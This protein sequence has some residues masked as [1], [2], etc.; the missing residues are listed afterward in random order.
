M[1]K[2]IFELAVADANVTAQLDK[3]RAQLKEINKELKSAEPGSE[4]FDK[5]AVEAQQAKSVIADLTQTQKALNREFAATKVPSDSLAGLRLEYSKLVQQISLLSEAERNGKVG[6]ELIRNA[7]GIKDQ[8]NGIQES[9]GNFTGSVGNYKGGILAAFDALQSLGGA[10]G[11]QAGVLQ[12]ARQAF[13]AA[14]DGAQRF[15][16]A[17]TKGVENIRQGR[18]D[19]AQYLESLRQSKTI[20]KEAAAAAG[21]AGE[22]V[23]EAAKEGVAAGAGLAESA[24]G[25]SLFARAGGVLKTVLSGLGIGLLISLL[26]GLIGVFQRFAP[27]IDLVEQ[28]AAGLSA[29]FDVLISRTGRLVDGFVKIFS[30]DFKAG[31]NEVAESVTGIGDAMASAATEAAGLKKELQDLEDAQ[32]DFVLQ[33]AQAEA[34]VK[35]LEVALKDRTRS[36]GNRLKIAAQIAAIESKNLKDKT[37]IIDKE[38]DIEKRRL[39]LTGQVTQEQANQIAAGNFELARQ[40]EDNFKLNADQTD[41]IRDLLVQRTNAEGESAV[42]LERIQNRKNAIL[43]AAA[44]KAAASAEKQNKAIEAQNARV[45]ELEKAVRDLD[46]SLILNDFDKQA[47]D[48]ENKRLDAIEKIAQQSAALKQKIQDAG[49]VLTDRDKEEQKLIEQETRGVEAAYKAQTD[50]LLKA[51]EAARA[52]QEAELKALFNEVQVLAKQNGEELANIESEILNSEFLKKQVELK[53]VLQQRQ[54]DLNQSLI[55]GA[56]TRKQFEQETIAAQSDFNIKS[57]TL[58]KERVDK[59]TQ[60]AEDLRNAKIASA[61]ASLTAELDAIRTAADADVQ[62]LRDRATKEGVDTTEQI[63]QREAQALEKRTAAYNNYAKTVNDANK[64]ATQ[65]QIE[66]LNAVNDAD[67][68]VQED[69]LRRIDEEKKKRGEL[70]DFLLSTANTIA[71]AIFDI[72]KN[73]QQ[74]QTETALQSLEEEYNKRKE[75]AAGNQ[76]QI[77]KIEKEY[78]ARKAKIEKAAAEERRKIALREA[79]IQGA[80]SVVKALPNAF[81]AIA[82]GIAAAAQIAIIA[83]QK[84][85]RGGSV[86]MGT[87]AGKR[88]SAGGTKGVFDDGTVIEVEKGEDFFVLNRAASAERQ[89]LSNLNYRFG[90]KRFESGGALSFTPQLSRGGSGQAE[91]IVVVTEATFSDEQIQII[92]KE[93]ATQTAQGSKVAIAEGLNDANR[94]IERERALAQNRAA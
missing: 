28:A 19:L 6:Q 90:G 35:K 26:V 15:G 60:L 92:A 71:G 44:E 86:K 82:A 67:A 22:A 24:K 61:R 48:I 57:A 87:F 47:A 84:F 59:Q 18:A 46:A 32:K 23:G 10:I 11:Q 93:V 74:Q 55:D 38:I 64:T 51:R 21:E 3:M 62:A 12:V 1:S 17:F 29:V 89:R 78:Q 83:S 91:R 34:A 7:A 56:I 42:L 58:E 65:T 75:K 68:K 41:R 94:R 27:V 20:Q 45:R 39:L 80:L 30:G 5:L 13:V 72:E 9:V 85:E 70:Q 73:R 52:K 16:Q 53:S 49:G 79:I 66:G 25:A 77:E 36:D 2:I 8:I 54:K 88:H 69:K 14:A 43:D 4:A 33:N 81:A 37:S 31:F 40:L 76:A 63:A 50:A